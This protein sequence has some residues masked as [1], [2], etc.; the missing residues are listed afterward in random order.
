M[1]DHTNL[2]KVEQCNLASDFSKPVQNPLHK[3]RWWSN[4]YFSAKSCWKTKIT[5]TCSR[6]ANLRIHRAFSFF[7]ILIW[8]TKCF[9]SM[10]ENKMFCSKSTFLNVKSIVSILFI[11]FL[12]IKNACL[13]VEVAEFHYFYW[14]TSCVS[15]CSFFLFEIPL[16]AFG[17]VWEQFS[18]SVM[19]L[20]ETWMAAFHFR[21][22]FLTGIRL[23]QPVVSA[24]AELCFIVLQ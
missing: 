14:E 5:F 8:E 9:G 12:S 1:N 4:F 3:T 21:V 13:V 22:S 2:G 16:K 6:N 23:T 19:L 20:R 11:F 18:P 17:P 10:M 7:G 15:A 24:H